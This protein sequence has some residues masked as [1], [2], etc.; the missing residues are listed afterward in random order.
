MQTENASR[1]AESCAVQHVGDR[2]SSEPS[3]IVSSVTGL[4]GQEAWSRPHANH[5]R[6][7]LASIPRVQCERTFPK[8]ANDVNQ[9][10]LAIMQWEKWK[11]MMSQRIEERLAF[12]TPCCLRTRRNS[13]KYASSWPGWASQFFVKEKMMMRLDEIGPNYE[14][15]KAKVLSYDQQDRANTRRTERV[16]CTDGGRTCL[17]QRAGRG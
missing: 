2:T 14:N 4:E 7:T 1:R 8:P 12:G 9:V 10:R 6:R 13:R 15:L 16:V 3:T 11:A 17:W 5:S